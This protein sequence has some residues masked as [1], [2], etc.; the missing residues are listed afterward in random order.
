MRCSIATGRFAHQFN[1]KIAQAT[2]TEQKIV[3]VMFF[4]DTGKQCTLAGTGPMYDHFMKTGEIRGYTGFGTR[5]AT[6]N[7]EQCISMR[8]H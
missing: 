7:E 6:F 5:P 2:E 4:L 3:N 1:L 8:R